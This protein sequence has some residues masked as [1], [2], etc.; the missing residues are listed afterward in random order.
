MAEVESPS[1]QET[2]VR[3]I[4][5]AIKSVSGEVDA[6]TYPSHNQPWHGM[7]RA[8]D[9]LHIETYHRTDHVAV[10]M[11]LRLSREG[12]WKTPTHSKP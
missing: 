12:S 9:I 7:A 1:L 8:I 2:C 3:H 10:S 6:I 4:D 11:M 5:Q